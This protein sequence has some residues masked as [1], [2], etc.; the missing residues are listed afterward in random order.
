MVED[1][2][3]KCVDAGGKMCMSVCVKGECGASNI[4]LKSV[5]EYYHEPHLKV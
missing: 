2:N 5:V 1:S 4:E 3:L